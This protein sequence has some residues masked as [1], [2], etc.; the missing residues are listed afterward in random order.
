MTKKVTTL[1]EHRAI[2]TALPAGYHVRWDPD[3]LTLHRGDGSMVAAFSTE[4]VV[5]TRVASV[6]A[7]DLTD[8]DQGTACRAGTLQQTMLLAKDKVTIRN[9][10]QDL[11][12]TQKRTR[13][14]ADT[15]L[16]SL[17]PER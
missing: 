16:R 8:T 2:K 15:T 6:A 7:D 4:G 12:K 9:P 14:S 11:D 3:I 10:H 5:T 1:G 13:I 17:S